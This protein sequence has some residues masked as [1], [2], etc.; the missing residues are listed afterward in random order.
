M[1][2]RLDAVWRTLLD[3]TPRW[4]P[5]DA[6]RHNAESERSP[7]ALVASIAQFHV[8]VAKRYKPER[9]KDGDNPRTFCNVFV[10]DVTRALNAEIPH[11]VDGA[12]EP[13]EVGHGF[14]Q[15]ANRINTWLWQHGQRFGWHDCTAEQ[16]R[17]VAAKGHPVVASWANFHGPGHVVVVTASPPYPQ[18]I[19]VAQAGVLRTERCKLKAA[20]G[21]RVAEFFWHP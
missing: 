19:H 12:G 2:P 16:A 6:P 14:E 21:S 17:T 20:F 9:D 11:W 18:Q 5:L 15:T 1:S 10:S 4:Q 13:S 7:Q 3:A 8:E